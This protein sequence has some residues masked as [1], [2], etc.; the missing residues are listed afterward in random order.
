MLSLTF[1][2]NKVDKAMKN[3]QTPFS[4]SAYL[5]SLNS[6]NLITLAVKIIKL[7]ISL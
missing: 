2:F 3:T 5:F 6:I 4:K 1:I 7:Y